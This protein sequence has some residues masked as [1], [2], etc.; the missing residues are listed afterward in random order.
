[1]REEEVIGLIKKRLKMKGRS[2]LVGPG[3]DTA[4]VSHD[5]NH[6][7]LLTTDCVVENVHFTRKQATLFQIG[8]KAMAVNLSDIAAMGGVP[9]YALASVGLPKGFSCREINQLLNGMQAMCDAYGFDLVGGNLTKSPV[10]FIDISLAGR[11]EKKYLKLRCGAKPGDLIFV[12]GTLG[13][14]LVKKHLN[15]VPRIEESRKIIKRAHVTA[16]MDVSDGISS[17][18]TRMAKASGT[19]FVI[20]LD[21]I[22]VSADAIGM[23]GTKE[24]AVSHALN[25]GEDYELLFTVSSSDADR[26]PKKVGSLPVTC[27]GRMTG[28][29]KYLGIGADGKKAKIEPSGFSH[30]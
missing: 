13:G 18:L 26:V 29:K 21:K 4:V 23:S 1:M 22:P 3:D 11:V 28:D 25:D 16:M 20:G 17:D 15:V 30:F 10:L 2:V 7:L 8:K 27:I 6:Y 19:G 24:E 9:L 5:K 14:T 12:T